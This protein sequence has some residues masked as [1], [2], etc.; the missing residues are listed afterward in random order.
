MSTTLDEPRTTATPLPGEWTMADLQEFL[1]NVP[2]RRIRLYPHP[3]TA[4]EDDALRVHDREGRLC[5][6]IDG[7]LVE[8]D[9]AS[10]E[11]LIAGLLI[12]L[13]NNYLIQHPLGVVLAGDGPLRILPTR[14]R[15]PDVS[16]IRWERF[17]HGRI[18]ARQ[19]VFQVAPDLAVEVLSQGNTREEMEIRLD[20]Y[21]R[22]G[23]P[24]IWYIDPHGRT[25]TVYTADGREETL[26]EDGVLDG[27]D[28]LPGFEVSLRE[29]FDHFPLD[30]AEQPA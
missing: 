17:P 11:S 6:L 4:T 21:R 15:M 12:Q 23:V 13:I 8:K 1:G 3:G 20:E 28:V 10:Y 2:A 9:M 14:T 30:E 24:L 19:K 25:A 5:E 27:G 22:A 7:I 18:P 26:G 16:F 29:L